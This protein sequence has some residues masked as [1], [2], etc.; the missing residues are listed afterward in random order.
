MPQ[1]STLS[2]RELNLLINTL[3][4]WERHEDTVAWRQAVLGAVSAVLGTRWGVFVMEWDP[5]P[6]VWLHRGAEGVVSGTGLPPGSGAEEAE[7]WR[8]L[9]GDEEEPAL[10]PFDGFIRAGRGVQSRSW[11]ELLGGCVFH[12]HPDGSRSWMGCFEFDG[13]PDQ[14]AEASLPL[15]RILVPAFQAGTESCRTGTAGALRLERLVDAFGEPAVLSRSDGSEARLNRALRTL[16]RS[17]PRFEELRLAVQEFRQEFL[18]NPDADGP[19]LT[20]SRGVY[21]LRGEFL[22]PA[23]GAGGWVVVK[24]EPSAPVLPGLDELQRRFGLTPRES[25]VALG[26]A[27]GLSD[28]ALARELEITWH[29]ARRHVERTLRKLDV[30][31]RA[32]V[33]DRLLTRD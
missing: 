7:G 33:M 12:G 19:E 16:E 26:L 3:H 28:K 18:A 27:K 15:I 6:T 30:S 17:E 20:L 32:K 11:E 8:S 24:I 21:R 22:D 5:V 13:A 2:L 14:F 23:E 9:F 10:P 29:T 25:E 31:A 4:D 1:I